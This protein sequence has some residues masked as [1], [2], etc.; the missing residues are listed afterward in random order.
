MN[1]TTGKWIVFIGIAIVILGIAV[2][3][4]ADKLRWLGHLPGDIRLEKENVRFYF[5]VT[6]MILLS[7]LLS[8]ALYLLRKFMG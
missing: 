6:T 1:S 5:P 8:L 3:F 4:F 2:Y 7:L